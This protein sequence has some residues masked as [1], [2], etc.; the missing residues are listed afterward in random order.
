MPAV[1]TTSGWSPFE[2]ESGTTTGEVITLK[3]PSDAPDPGESL[4]LESEYTQT[5]PKFTAA[6]SVA[7]FAG[8]PPPDTI[9]VFI[10]GDVALAATDTVAVIDE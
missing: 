8:K 7:L 2:S 4:V 5:T 6:E 9:A 1:C 10:C 3:L